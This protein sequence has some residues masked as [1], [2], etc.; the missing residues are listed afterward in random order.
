MTISYR[1]R[2]EPFAAQYLEAIAKGSRDTENELTGSEIERFLRECGV[3]DP[4]PSMTRWK[5]LCPG[6]AESQNVLNREDTADVEPQQ[7][8]NS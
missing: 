3:P 8:K 2:V 1:N 5:R 6:L 7:G 4:T